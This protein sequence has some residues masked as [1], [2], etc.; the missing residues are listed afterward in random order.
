[1]PTKTANH[2][3]LRGRTYYFRVRVPKEFADV[4]PLA[5]INRSLKT[6]DPTEAAARAATVRMALFAE[7]QAKRAGLVADTRVIFDASM[8]ILKDWGMRFCSM[9]DLISGPV[10]QLLSRIEA[11]TDVDPSSSAGLGTIYLPDVLIHETA[12]R[13]PIL[14]EAEIRDKS[15]RQ[16][17]ELCQQA[18][19]LCSP[20]DRHA[21]QGHSVAVEQAKQRLGRD[22]GQKTNI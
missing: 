1:M 11:L 22:E 21:L 9:E 19:P 7:W 5:E 10:E 4:E 8:D 12:L 16:R 15:A 6:R 20:N 3:E 13:M 2:V 18:N 17:R 14:K